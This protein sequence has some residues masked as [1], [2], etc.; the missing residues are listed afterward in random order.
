MSE[1][2]AQLE[3]AREGNTI[4]ATLTGEIDISNSKLLEQEIKDSVSQAGKVIVDL[5]PLGF[6][7]SQG[8]RLIHNL[9]SHLSSQGVGFEIVAPAESIAGQVLHLTKM[10]ELV[11]VRETLASST[12]G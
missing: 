12:D 5:S 9:A 10:D 11:S 7:D 3:I 8:V 2:L 4:L 6:M 1:N